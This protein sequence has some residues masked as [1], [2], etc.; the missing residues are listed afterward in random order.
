MVSR[1]IIPDSLLRAAV[2]SAVRTF[3]LNS[4]FELSG[5]K[6]DVAEAF[7]YEKGGIVIL[8]LQQQS[9]EYSKMLLLS[10][11]SEAWD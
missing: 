11:M 10:G 2:P 3:L 6:G 7:S 8:P 9:H 1:F 4:G 5:R